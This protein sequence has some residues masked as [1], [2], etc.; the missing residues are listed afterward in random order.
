VRQKIDLA[1]AMEAVAD[2]PARDLTLTELVR[3]YS[4]AKCDGS[5]SRLRKW[6][7]AFGATSA[8]AVAPE[9]LETA[10]QAMLDHGY[11]PS[12]VNR[13]WRRP[14]FEPLSPGTPTFR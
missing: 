9:Q 8:W 1:S 13:C 7:A 2:Q 5:D 10:A 4:V 14:R 6:T 12:A 11:K 3:A